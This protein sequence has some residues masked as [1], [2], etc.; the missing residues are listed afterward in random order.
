MKA[1]TAL[2]TAGAAAAIVMLGSFATTVGAQRKPAPPTSV[3]VYVF[4]CGKLESADPSRFS[5]KR[6]EMATTDMSVACYLVVHPRGT[7]MWD[8]GAVPDGDVTS[9]GTATRY[10]IV[11]PNGNER[12]VTTTQPLKT[13]L[14]AAGYAPGDISF[15]ALSHYHYDHTAN[16]NLFAGATWL[17][18]QVERD[19]MF[20]QKPNDLTRP[21]TYSALRASK[22]TIIKTDDYDVFGD[23]SVVL[24]LTPGH[25][26]GHNVLF[27]KLAKTG[28]V[29]ISGDLYHYPEERSLHRV[30]TF[31]AD[32]KQTAASR[33][34]LDAFLAKEKAQL[35]IQ[36]DFAATAKMKK[37]PAYYE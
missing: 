2:K 12:F 16:A 10:H 3:R 24:K 25:T 4:D 17:V 36:H 28:P 22:T 20:P 9:P 18:R 13:Q 15:L 5:L 33:T 37:A 8:V 21:D 23:G 1:L 29:V 31:D 27:V 34:A 11:L 14:A 19:V 6:E 35:W 30:P 7:L 26:P 32:P